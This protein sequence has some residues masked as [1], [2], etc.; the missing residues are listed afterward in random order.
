V[1]HADRQVFTQGTT[2]WT[3]RVNLVGRGAGRIAPFGG[4]GLVIG[5]EVFRQSLEFTNCVPPS[6]D[7]Q[8]LT[9]R[10]FSRRET[11]YNAGFQGFGGVEVAVTPRVQGFMTVRY[12]ARR[13]LAYGTF[14]FTGG[15][16]VT[17]R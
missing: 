9:C 5:R 15:V 8:H 14:G 11:S 13:D 1:G 10:D 4:G 17:L 12:E 7:P 16:R 6:V 2:D 3:T